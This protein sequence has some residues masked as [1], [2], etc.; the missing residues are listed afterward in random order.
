[1]C[2][3]CIQDRFWA[4]CASAQGPG[5]TR[6]GDPLQFQWGYS[7]LHKLKQQNKLEQPGTDLAA[8][9]HS[10]L[11]EKELVC[12]PFPPCQRMPP[13]NPLHTLLDLYTGQAQLGQTHPSQSLLWCGETT[14]CLVLTYPP[15]GVV[16]KYIMHF[17]N[18]SGLMQGICAGRRH[19]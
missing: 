6:P 11:P 2:L 18:V 4:A 8:L 10:Y 17:H 14:P 3:C 13:S 1:M 15:L 12:C 7:G 5:E 16:Q 19:S 9:K